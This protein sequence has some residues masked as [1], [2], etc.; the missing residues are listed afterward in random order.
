MKEIMLSDN[1]HSMLCDDEDF[2]LLSSISWT[3]THGYATKSQWKQESLFAHKL[4]MN[5]SQGQMV[6]HKDR[7]KL[8]NQKDNLR[9]CTDSQNQANKTKSKN[10]KSGYKGVCWN[11]SKQ[12]YVARIGV[13][14][15]KVECGEFKSPHDAAIAYN[16]KAVELYGE[17]AVLN[18]IDNSLP[19]ITPEKSNEY[20]PL[21]SISYHKRDK[22]YRI[23]YCGKYIGQYKTLEEAEQ[24]LSDYKLNLTE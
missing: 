6:D 7:N 24:K 5:V 23:T 10:N 22:K 11:K 9:L 13:N 3:Y 19:I 14:N 8:N 12:R 18:E 17:F 15:K 16:N 2:D 1:I 20:K 21:G 4:V